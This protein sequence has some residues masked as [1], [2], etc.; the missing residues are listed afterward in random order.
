[1]SLL[2]SLRTPMRSASRSAKTMTPYVSTSASATAT[3]VA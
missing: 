3:W 2:R 1:M